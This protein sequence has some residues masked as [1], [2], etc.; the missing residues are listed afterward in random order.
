[1]IGPKY[2]LIF[3]NGPMSSTLLV[4]ENQ[5]NK[6]KLLVHDVPG[7][8]LSIEGYNI[9]SNVLCFDVNNS[10]LST[11]GLKKSEEKETKTNEKTV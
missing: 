7:R 5:L 8:Q 1:M 2:E 9:F 10:L 6:K 11:E 4:I 3:C